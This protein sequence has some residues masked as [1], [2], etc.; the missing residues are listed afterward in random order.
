MGIHE[1]VNG[2]EIDLRE[3]R[4]DLPAFAMSLV[5]A[6]EILINDGEGVLRHAHKPDIFPDSLRRK[7]LN[8]QYRE[9]HEPL[10]QLSERFPYVSVE[11]GGNYGIRV[12]HITPKGSV[13]LV[14]GRTSN[15]LP[16]SLKIGQ[17]R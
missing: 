3:F 2:V 16:D 4:R 12:A 7:F 8:P 1:G 13:S 17:H 5:K 10:F 6:L 9:V 11:G 15:R 14:T